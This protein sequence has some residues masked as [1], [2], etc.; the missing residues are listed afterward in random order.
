MGGQHAVNELE[1]EEE[2]L[3]LSDADMNRWYTR[4]KFAT[5]RYVSYL[6][7]AQRSTCFQRRL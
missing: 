1:T 6:I 2:L 7:A 4:L 5:E 3:V